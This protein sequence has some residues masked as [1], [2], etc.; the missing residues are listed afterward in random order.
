MKG[1]M[2]VVYQALA[3]R[4][5]DNRRISS[6]IESGEHSQ[7]ELRRYGASHIERA[8]VVPANQLWFQVEE[9]LTVL[10]QFN[11]ACK[12]LRGLETGPTL[13]YP[14][15]LWYIRSPMSFHNRLSEEAQEL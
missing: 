15:P 12:L 3:V 1:G 9:I 6:I 2:R 5:N 7:A 8:F 14:P 11:I 4:P 10:L 13:I